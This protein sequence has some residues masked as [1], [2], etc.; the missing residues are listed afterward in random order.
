MD[1]EAVPFGYQDTYKG[2]AD[3]DFENPV[4]VPGTGDGE[5]RVEKTGPKTCQ[6]IVMGNGTIGQKNTF[7]VKIDGHLGEGEAEIVTEFAY[8]VVSPD[9]TTIGFTKV[10]RTPIPK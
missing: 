2:E 5:Q 9:A 7:S 3:E 4:I 8:D 10:G 1:L 6:L